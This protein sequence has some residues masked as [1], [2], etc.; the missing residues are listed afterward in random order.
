MP[1]DKQVKIRHGKKFKRSSKQVKAEHAQNETLNNPQ[2][3]E[4]TTEKKSKKSKKHKEPKV[5]FLQA[6]APEFPSRL[7]K[8]DAREQKYMYEDNQFQ[9]YDRPETIGY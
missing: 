7:F 1:I 5:P 9:G 4:L 3:T 6:I 8:I 2:E